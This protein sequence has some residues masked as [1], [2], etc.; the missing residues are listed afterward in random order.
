MHEK[1]KNYIIILKLSNG[2]LNMWWKKIGKEQNG[3][4][5]S[6]FDSSLPIAEIVTIEKI[7]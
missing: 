1:E 2:A 6:V 3:D 7:K 4:T 5:I